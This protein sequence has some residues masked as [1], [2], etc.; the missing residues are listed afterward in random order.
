MEKAEEIEVI[1]GDLH[2]KGKI[3]NPK[4]FVKEFLK[5]R[6][7]RRYLKKYSVDKT[8]PDYTS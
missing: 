5:D 2:F 7:I 4:E 3:K 1:V 8:I 6:T